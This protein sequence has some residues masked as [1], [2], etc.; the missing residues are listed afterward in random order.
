LTALIQTISS[1][2]KLKC[3][4]FTNF[5]GIIQTPPNSCGAFALAAALENF[6]LAPQQPQA[7][8][9]NTDDLTQGY[10][11]QPG[12]QISNEGG[13]E[14]FA[15]AIYQ[16]TG[17]LLLGFGDA[18]YRYT[19]PVTNMNPPSALVYVATL[20]GY[21][22]NQIAVFYTNEG[23]ALF[24]PIPVLNPGAGS[25]LLDTEIEL[26]GRINNGGGMI[27]AGPTDYLAVPPPDGK[28]QIVLVQQGQHWLAINHTQLYDPGTG[29]VGAYTLTDTDGDLSFNYTTDEVV[30]ENDFSG[31]WIELTSGA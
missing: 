5:N 26:L 7:D 21:P 19:A 8:L 11:H 6:A 27:I 30:R 10:T 4:P 24:S 23:S 20:F 3:M 9:L 29:F 13:A 15:T 14:A 25:N 18:T 31:I 1:S 22:T 16:V 28:V 2:Y 12:A 17:N